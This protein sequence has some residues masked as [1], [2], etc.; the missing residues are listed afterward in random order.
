M[1]SITKWP[2][3]IYVRLCFF[4]HSPSDILLGNPSLS[5]PSPCW[6]TDGFSCRRTI[7]AQAFGCVTFVLAG[8]TKCICGNALVLCKLLCLCCLPFLLCDVP[9]RKEQI[10]IELNKFSSLTFLWGEQPFTQVQ[11]S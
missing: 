6:V 3:T 4:F 9:R 8:E 7:A 5:P 1:L 2:G 11:T 10:L